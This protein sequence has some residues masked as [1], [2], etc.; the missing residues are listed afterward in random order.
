M[1]TA[2]F[3][4]QI[5]VASFLALLRIAAVRDVQ[6][7]RIPNAVTLAVLILYPLHLLYSPMPVDW[8]SALTV[9]C[10]ALLVGLVLFACHAVGAGDVQ[11]LAA[12][13]LWAGPG[14][15]PAALRLHATA[16]GGIS[17]G[18]VAPG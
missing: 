11:L 5:V 7:Y 9:F 15:A 10:V 6:T 1:S 12:V 8:S 14:L 13:L 16:G 18:Q 3:A 4:H 17:L 2:V